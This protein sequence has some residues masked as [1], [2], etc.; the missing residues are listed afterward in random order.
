MSYHTADR[1]GDPLPAGHEPTSL[2]WL[3]CSGVSAVYRQPCRYSPI[4]LVGDN[5]ARCV[6][7]LQVQDQG[8]E[9]TSW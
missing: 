2:L 7:P 1:L 3:A 5:L 4:S 6:Y 9:C 8:V